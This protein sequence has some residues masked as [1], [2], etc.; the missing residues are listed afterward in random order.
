MNR[1]IIIGNGF[2]LAHGLKTS[3]KDFLEWIKSKI[4][5][6]PDEYFE[7]IS[8]S[9]ADHYFGTGNFKASDFFR[10]YY[11]K[12]RKLDDF[13]SI[14]SE[15]KF[16]YKNKFLE[17]LINKQDLEN[18]V[19]IEEEYFKKLKMCFQNYYES[20]S[21]D[22]ITKLNQDFTQ[23]KNDLEEY[24]CLEKGKSVTIKEKLMTS[25]IK[26]FDLNDNISAIPTELNN[27]L[28]LNF[29]YTSYEKYYAKPHMQT[30]Y[31]HGE[32]KNEKNPIIFGYGDE[33]TEIYKEIKKINRNEFLTNM[34]LFK[35]FNV[36]NY[37]KL[38]RFIKSAKYQIYIWGHSC[39]N[40]DG[41]LLKEL[42]EDDNCVSIRPF[43]HIFEDG[44]NNY[45]DIVMNIARH[46]LDDNAFRRKVMNRELCE[47]LK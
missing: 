36:S 13:I 19:D 24:L 11:I 37:S 12:S 44:S 9:T 5:E 2:D 43:Y 40:S 22:S 33:D 45:S 34:K 32:L 20:Q 35:Y 38:V 1:I 46:F 23:I 10:R 4:V 42:F 47:E 18:W 26:P 25:I 7:H 8:T 16:V 27:V 28:F 3:Y 29:N 21:I 39:G 30:I 41:T 17:Y 15:C 31:I 6:N 14:Y